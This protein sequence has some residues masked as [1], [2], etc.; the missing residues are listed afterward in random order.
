M[1]GC[2]GYIL[3]GGEWRWM[4]VSGYGWLCVVVGS[5]DGGGWWWLVS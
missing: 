3:A 2:V 4:V 1:V 5:V